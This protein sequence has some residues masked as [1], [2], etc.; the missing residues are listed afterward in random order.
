MRSLSFWLLALPMASPGVVS[1]ALVLH[2]T[3]IFEEAGLSATLAAG[4]FVIFSVSA[5]ITSLVGGFLVERGDPKILY[6]FTMLMLLVGLLLVFVINS[7]FIAVLYVI[8]MGIANGSHHIV[9][10]V[11]WAHFYGRNGLGR[12]Q[13]PAMMI[14]ISGAAIGPLPLALLHD[15]SGSYSTGILLMMSLPILSLVSII[16]ARPSTQAGQ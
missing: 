6:G 7:T 1:T 2:Q 11:I 8:V 9:Q 13:G 10:G 5:A 14:G 15:L 12:I 16:L 3:S 4:V